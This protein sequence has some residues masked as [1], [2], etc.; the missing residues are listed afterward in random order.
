M[1]N[2]PAP[3]VEITTIIKHYDRDEESVPVIG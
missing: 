3:P 1:E 2:C